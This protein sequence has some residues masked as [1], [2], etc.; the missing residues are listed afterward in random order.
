MADAYAVR[1]GLLRYEPGDAEQSHDAQGGDDEERGPPA[2]GLSEIRAEG[3]ADDVGDGESGEHHG[4]GPGLLLRGDQVG[5]DHRADAEKGT[6]REG[7][8]HTAGEHDAE[9]RGE[10]GHHIAHDEQPH[11]QHQHALTG[12]TGAQQ[13]HQRG[14]EDHTER[15]AGHQEA[16][17]RDRDLEITGDLGEQPHDHELGRSDPEC[18]DGESEERQRHGCDLP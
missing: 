11:E 5:S 17:S 4:D 10:R 15:V 16:R 12:D 14:S 13:R 2:R 18:P 8:D 3:N 6:V 9:D 7:S 1:P